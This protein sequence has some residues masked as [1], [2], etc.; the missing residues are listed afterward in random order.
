[1]VIQATLAVTSTSGTETSPPPQLDGALQLGAKS[2]RQEAEHTQPLGRLVDAAVV[3]QE[4]QAK[5]VRLELVVED[6]PVATGPGHPVKPV[7]RPL[8]PCDARRRLTVTAETCVVGR[9]TDLPG[10]SRT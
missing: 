6:L 4:A 9:S 8:P 10:A 7:H 1:M 2:R 5:S 3:Q